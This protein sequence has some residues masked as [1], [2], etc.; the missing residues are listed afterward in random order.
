MDNNI[1]FRFVWRIN[2]LLFLAIAGFATYFLGTEAF[3]SFA[4]R[5]RGLDIDA[6]QAGEAPS[7]PTIVTRTGDIRHAG[8]DVY[9]ADVLREMEPGSRSQKGFSRYDA[10]SA[11]VNILLFNAATGDVQPLFPDNSGFIV[12]EF[13][14]PDIRNKPPLARFYLYVP[15]DSNGDKRLTASDLKQVIATRPDGSG[16]VLIADGVDEFQLGAVGADTVPT[17]GYFTRIGDVSR[18]GSLDLATF[19]PREGPIVEIPKI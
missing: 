7:A 1:V 3:R 14:S 17:L 9:R 18:F 8:G 4:P 5:D 2:A 15:A 16:K 13:P 12:S 11:K 19:V 6:V 10:Q